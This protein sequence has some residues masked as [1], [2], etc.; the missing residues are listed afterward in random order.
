MS[1]LSLRQSI[2]DELEFQPDKENL[3]YPRAIKCRLLAGMAFSRWSIISA[4]LPNGI[5]TQAHN[6]YA[7]YNC[8]W[9]Y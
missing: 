2:L 5:Y 1:D 3:Q 4:D 8:I 6:T 7:L 9:C